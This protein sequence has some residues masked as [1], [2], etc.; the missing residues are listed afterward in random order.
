MD[1]HVGYGLCKPDFSI[2]KKQLAT[3]Q[4]INDA[5]NFIRMKFNE[6]LNERKIYY[7]NEAGK[8]RQ[9][10]VPKENRFVEQ[11]EITNG[12]TKLYVPGWEISAVVYNGEYQ[13]EYENSVSM[14]YIRAEKIKEQ[15]VNEGA[16]EV[17]V[18]E[19]G[20][21]VQLH[22]SN[23]E[24]FFKRVALDG[25]SDEQIASM[26]NEEKIFYEAYEMAPKLFPDNSKYVIIHQRVNRQGIIIDTVLYR[27]DN[28][29]FMYVDTYRKIY[30]QYSELDSVRK[31]MNEHSMKKFEA[32]CCT[33]GQDKSYIKMEDVPER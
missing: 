28:Q 16:M 31:Y 22:F 5:Q 9:I 30:K 13:K 1:I 8:D 3:F 17:S 20:L 7:F 19:I 2:Q 26:P 23:I 21:D 24:T 33:A 29:T 6:D 4:D 12:I 27:P 14:D 15:Y 18:S 10:F 32:I 25:M 11:E